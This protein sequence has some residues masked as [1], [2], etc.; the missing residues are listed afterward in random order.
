MGRIGRQLFKYLFVENVRPVH[1]PN[2]QIER[3]RSRGDV[4]GDG[5]SDAVAPGAHVL[6]S[7]NEN[8]RIVGVIADCRFRFCRTDVF[9]PAPA[10]IDRAIPR[11]SD[12]VGNAATVQEIVFDS[13]GGIALYP[14]PAECRHELAPARYS[15]RDIDGAFAEYADEG[16]RGRADRS[17]GSGA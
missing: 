15:R 8:V 6:G 2:D 17:D 10:V 4:G 3:V 5:D 16:G 13:V 12:H 7:E 11:R 9:R 1:L 14:V